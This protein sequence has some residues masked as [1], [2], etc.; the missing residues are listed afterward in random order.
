MASHVIAVLKAQFEFLLS[1]LPFVLMFMIYQVLSGGKMV[2]K[3]K[4]MSKESPN[5][6]S[7]SGQ[8]PKKCPQKASRKCL[9]W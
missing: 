5:Q 6:T 4:H 2:K 8:I 9:K 1:K 3:V 7:N